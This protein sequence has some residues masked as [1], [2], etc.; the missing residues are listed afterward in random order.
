MPTDEWEF[1]HFFFIIIIEPFPK[2]VP[3]KNN[4]A[5]GD[6]ITTFTSN[7]ISG[8]SLNLRTRRYDSGTVGTMDSGSLA[9]QEP[10]IV[11]GSAVHSR[12]GGVILTS[13]MAK[14]TENRSRWGNYHN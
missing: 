14:S 12:A 4:D 5:P 2:V 13:L 11:S 8:L 3:Q 9:S 10:K 6:T 7:N 1:S